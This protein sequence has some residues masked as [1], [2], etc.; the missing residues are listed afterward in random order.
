MKS[1]I[2]K[3]GLDNIQKLLYEKSLFGEIC[4]DEI[5]GYDENLRVI[6]SNNYK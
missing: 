1:S 4:K 3:N 5:I 2:K 6:I